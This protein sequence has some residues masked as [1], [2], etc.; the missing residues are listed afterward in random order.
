L[1][2]PRLAPGTGGRRPGAWPR[3]AGD[4]D[5]RRR[6]P[7]C[8]G[9][10][11]QTFPNQEETHNGSHQPAARAGAGRS[12]G[13]PRRCSGL[14]AMRNWRSSWHRRDYQGKRA[15]QCKN[16][17]PVEGLDFRA[18]LPR[19][20]CKFICRFGGASAAHEEAGDQKDSGGRSETVED[21]REFEVLLDVR[22]QC[23]AAREHGECRGVTV[24]LSSARL[25]LTRIRLRIRMSRAG[26]PFRPF[27]TLSCLSIGLTA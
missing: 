24:S 19:S 20:L 1:L 27:I 8:P 16:G 17:L 2:I 12:R 11:T 7:A 26:G 25:A 14:T 4:N 21:T 15:G 10:S 5:S 6:E 23:H 13:Q 9:A 3:P 22:E 18:C